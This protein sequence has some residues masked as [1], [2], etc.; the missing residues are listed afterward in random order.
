MIIDNDH[1]TIHIESEV[2]CLTINLYSIDE[3]TCAIEFRKQENNGQVEY[4]RWCESLQE[5]IGNFLTVQGEKE[6]MIGSPLEG[7]GG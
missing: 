2:E 5:L 7:A 3:T 1:Y 6:E 4:N